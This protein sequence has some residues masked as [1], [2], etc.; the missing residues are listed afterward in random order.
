SFDIDLARHLRGLFF[1]RLL[2]QVPGIDIRSSEC[3]SNRQTFKRVTLLIFT[4]QI[5]DIRKRNW[6]E[7]RALPILASVSSMSPPLI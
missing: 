6:P 4:K 3:R 7:N 5:T 2:R 1:A